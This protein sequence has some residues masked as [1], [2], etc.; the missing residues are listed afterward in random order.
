MWD[1]KKDLLW[2]LCDWRCGKEEEEQVQED[3]WTLWSKDFGRGMIYVS[4][5]ECIGRCGQLSLKG[6]ASSDLHQFVRIVVI[7]S[8]T[9]TVS[10]FFCFKGNC[11]ARN[12]R[13]QNGARVCCQLALHQRACGAFVCSLW[14]A[15]SDCSLWSAQSFPPDFGTQGRLTS[16]QQ[17]SIPFVDIVWFLGGVFPHKYSIKFI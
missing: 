8:L 4:G 6:S 5:S 3:Q 7:K 9:V 15:H 17:R 1:A 14:S 12:M 2:K 16:N 13:Q 11:G 10:W